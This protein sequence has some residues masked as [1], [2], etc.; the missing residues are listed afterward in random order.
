[1]SVQN[2]AVQALCVFCASSDRVD[3]KYKKLAE[4]LGQF[5]A[6]AQ[7]RLVYGGA[8]E[9][10][11]GAAATAALE[12]GGDVIGVMPEILSS[13]ER[14]HQNLTEL[15]VTADM[16]QRQQKMADLADV[17]VILPGGLGTLAEFFEIVTWKQI[18]LHQ[19]P[20]L[21]LNAFGFWDSL[22]Q[23]LDQAREEGFL[24]D[25]PGALFKIFDNL[26]DIKGFLSSI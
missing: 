8:Q 5:C 1:M 7:I 14:A 15:H 22:L 26:N 11:M 3:E 6:H 18:G 16:H 20:V 24:Y 10:L 12:R 2:N 9:G 19:K 17:F 4:E 23:G 25:D 21:L 13:R